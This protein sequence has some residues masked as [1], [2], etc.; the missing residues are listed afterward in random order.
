MKHKCF[1]SARGDEEKCSVCGKWETIVRCSQCKG[2]VCARCRNSECPGRG[3]FTP[4]RGPL[5]EPML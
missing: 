4:D 3:G 5:N 2:A 1:A